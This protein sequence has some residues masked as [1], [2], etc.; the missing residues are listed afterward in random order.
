MAL[1]LFNDPLMAMLE[2]GLELGV[3]AQGHRNP[4]D[5]LMEAVSGGPSSSWMLAPRHH[6]FDIVET[7]DKFEFVADAPGFT[8]EEITVALDQGV[9]TIKGKHAE[10]RKEQGTDGKV[11]RS[12]RHAMTFSR[13]FTLPDNINAEDISANLDKGVLKVCVPKVPKQPKQE[14]KRIAV[15]ML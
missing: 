5:Q 14:P 10:E 11:W 15:N 1:S 6:A 7:N 9:L 8:P 12:E 4:L 13:A 2:P 3:N